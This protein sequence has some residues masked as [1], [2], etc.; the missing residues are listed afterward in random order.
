LLKPDFSRAAATERLRV[1][2]RL[3]SRDFL[4]FIQGHAKTRLPL[5][6]IQSTANKT[7]AECGFRIA[8]LRED[9]FNPQSEIRIPQFAWPLSQERF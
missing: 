4:R 7:I 2:F 5:H 6:T 1:S 3:P 8:D 9:S